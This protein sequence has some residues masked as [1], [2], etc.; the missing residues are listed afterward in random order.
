MREKGRVWSCGR[1]LVCMLLCVCVCSCVCSCACV[2]ARVHAS[3]R[4][5]VREATATS[6]DGKGWCEVYLKHPQ[7]SSRSRVVAKVI[8]QHK[9]LAN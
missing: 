5:C 6:G 8:T 2:C 7:N 1:V 4:V 9:K 3:V